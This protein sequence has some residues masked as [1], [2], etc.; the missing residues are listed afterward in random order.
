MSTSR[1][2]SSTRS[3]CSPAT[4]NNV[5]GNAR[6]RVACCRRG[7]R[8]PD[9][10]GIVIPI[11]VAPR[12]DTRV[13][14]PIAAAT[15]IPLAP[16]DAEIRTRPSRFVVSGCDCGV[17]V[18]GDEVDHASS[19]SFEKVDD[20]GAGDGVHAD[21]AWFGTQGSATIRDRCGAP[22]RRGRAVRLLRRCRRRR[23]VV[24][25]G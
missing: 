3:S 24:R 17:E 6:S 7:D 5:L 11:L 23:R 25:D 1:P 20:A 13:G 14:H 4:S 10:A 19:A 9:R 2:S 12:F 22:R 18:V 21:L 8:Q 15:S 16:N